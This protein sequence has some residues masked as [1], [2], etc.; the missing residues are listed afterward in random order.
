[1]THDIGLYHARYRYDYLQKGDDSILF[2]IEDEILKLPEV[3]RKQTLIDSV[4]H[5]KH[6]I[7]MMVLKKPGKTR[8][9]YWIAVGYNS[10]IRFETMFNFYVWPTPIIIKYLDTGNGK[11]ITLAQWRKSTDYFD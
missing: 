2:K 3:Q 1:M 11:V 5:H 6:G 4:S 7:S 10:E 9:Y 8:K